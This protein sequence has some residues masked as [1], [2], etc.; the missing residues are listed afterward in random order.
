MV[1]H[2]I[3]A[4]V[5]YEEPV[6]ITAAVKA[7]IASVAA[8]ARYNRAELGRRGN[9]NAVRPCPASGRVRHRLHCRMPVGRDYPGPYEWFTQISGATVSTVSIISIGPGV[10]QKFCKGT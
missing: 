5:R 7:G 6:Q 9:G 8:F 4:A 2:R 3:V 10:P 1:G